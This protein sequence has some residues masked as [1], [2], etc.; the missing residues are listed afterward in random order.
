MLLHQIN[1]RSHIPLITLVLGAL[2]V[3]FKVP[4]AN[5]AEFEGTVLVSGPMSVQLT[6]DKEAIEPQKAPVQSSVAKVDCRGGSLVAAMDCVT[7]HIESAGTTSSA[8]GQTRERGSAEEDTEGRPAIHVT[9][10]GKITPMVVDQG[11]GK[12]LLQIES[13]MSIPQWSAGTPRDIIKRAAQDDVAL[14][15]GLRQWSMQLTASQLQKEPEQEADF[16]APFSNLS[17]FTV[18]APQPQSFKVVWRSAW[19]DQLEEEFRQAQTDYIA[20][21]SSMPVL[22]QIELVTRTLDEIEDALSLTAEGSTAAADKVAELTE[23]KTVNEKLDEL[24][25][26]TGGLS[27]ALTGA[28]EDIKTRLGK[29]HEKLMKSTGIGDPLS[30]VQK[31]LEKNAKTMKQV[32][33]T[34]EGM[35]NSIKEL[36]KLFSAADGKASD[37]LRAFKDYFGAVQEKLGPLIKAIPGL[38]VFLDLYGQAIGQIADS[39]ERIEKIVDQRNKQARDAGIPEPYVKTKTARER[40]EAEKNRLEKQMN[41]LADRIAKECPG[42]DLSG[43][44]YGEIQAIEDAKHRAHEACQDR[45]MNLSDEARIRREFRDAS[46]G[47]SA[48]N[49]TRAQDSYADMLSAYKELQNLYNKVKRNSVKTKDDRALVNNYFKSYYTDER[50]TSEYERNRG[51]YIGGRYT[52][53]D[54][55]E[56]GF[57]VDDQKR[58]LRQAQ[59][60][61]NEEREKKARYDKAK[62]ANDALNSNNRDYRNCVKNY[63][64]SLAKESGWNQRL[65]EVLNSE[66]F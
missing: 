49:V 42:F 28:L 26:D 32:A 37:Q 38:G 21:V 64:Q 10:S 39:A 5:A 58:L 20:H 51:R 41:D 17:L 55:T 13:A 12:F 11:N 22:D 6:Y 7:E 25:D 62:A 24:M 54:V 2:L 27:S 16:S 48:K 59:S 65:V 23:L 9:M 34:I 63:I 8:D 36:G 53:D 33:E 52:K 3:L 35:N 19:C 4:C 66:V 31:G 40:A 46:R 45:R 60:K 18:R 15:V 57:Y 30:K 61:R 47:Y 29:E 1:N 50:R 43:Q 44:E 56:L 14:K